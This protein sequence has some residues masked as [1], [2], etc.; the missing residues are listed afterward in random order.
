MNAEVYVTN[1]IPWNGENRTVVVTIYTPDSDYPV[2]VTSN[3]SDD[4]EIDKGPQG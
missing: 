1:N 4:A 3:N 2:R